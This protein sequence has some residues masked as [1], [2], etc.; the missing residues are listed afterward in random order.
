M[1][2]ILYSQ[3]EFMNLLTYFKDLKGNQ[4]LQGR[5]FSITKIYGTGVA[6]HKLRIVIVLTS[7]IYFLLQ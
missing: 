5:P 3:I 4:S 6:S 2:K 1:P 7:T